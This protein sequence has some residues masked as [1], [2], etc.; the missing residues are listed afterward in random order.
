MGERRRLGECERDTHRDRERQRETQRET[1]E[2]EGERAI[3]RDGSERCTD[4]R[5]GH[6]LGLFM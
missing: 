2:G 1:E 4:V 6:P 5:T 3:G